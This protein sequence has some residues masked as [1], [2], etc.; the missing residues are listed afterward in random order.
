MQA[1]HLPLDPAEFSEYVVAFRGCEPYDRSFAQ[2]LERAPGHRGQHV[3]VMQELLARELRRVHL[4]LF[5]VGACL[6][7]EQRVREHQGARLRAA[8][9]KG[10]HEIAHLSGRQLLAGDRLDQALA[11]LPVGARQRDQALHRR[12]R[13]DLT[14]KDS[15]L[16]RFRKVA[17]QREPPAHPAHA[18]IETPGEI[19]ERQVEAQVQLAQP[20]PLLERRLLGGGPHQS[21]EQQ[22]VGFFQVPAGGPDHVAT[23]ALHRPDPLVPVHDDEALGLLRGHHHDRHLLTVLCQ[24]SQQ[25]PLPLRAPHPEV[26]VAKNQ[27]V[28]LEVHDRVRLLDLH[29]YENRPLEAM[30]SRGRRR[31]SQRTCRGPSTTCERTASRAQTWSTL[32]VSSMATATCSPT[33]SRATCQSIRRMGSVVSVGALVSPSRT[34]RRRSRSSRS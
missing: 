19:L 23:E 11:S 4:G 22:R 34:R 14:A 12:V 25:P 3:E 31:R 9:A 5:P 21:A 18:S 32:P 33:A 8:G 24:G 30:P 13:G 7:H 1:V 20:Q 2:P 17:D 6:E 29:L 27:L 26:L 16:D 10:R 28:V 15:S